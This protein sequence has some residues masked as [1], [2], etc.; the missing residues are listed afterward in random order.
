MANAF[1]IKMCLGVCLIYKFDFD[2]GQGVWCSL[3]AVGFRSCG[4]K[5]KECLRIDVYSKRDGM[6]MCE[7]TNKRIRVWL[8]TWLAE[9]RSVRFNERHCLKTVG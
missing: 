2:S 4:Q 8:P 9:L 1:L 7:H 6:P 3:P 5:R